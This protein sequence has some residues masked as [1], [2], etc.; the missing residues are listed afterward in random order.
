M[1][2]NALNCYKS[3]TVNNASAFTKVTTFVNSTVEASITFPLLFT[4]PANGALYFTFEKG[5]GANGLQYFYCYNVNTTTWSGCSGTAT[6]GQM[7]NNTTIGGGTTFLSGLPQWDKT[8]GY[9]WFKWEWSQSVTPFW[10][11][12]DTAGGGVPCGPSLLGWTGSGF[13]NLAGTAQT[14]PL[15]QTGSPPVVTVHANIGPSY[16]VLDSISIDSNENLYMPYIDVDGS[17]FLQVYVIVA[18]LHTGTV[19]S[20]IQLTSNNSAFNPPASA[21][22][23][24]INPNTCTTAPYSCGS[25]TQAVTA[26]AVGSCAHVTYADIFNWGAGQADFY[27]CNA[28][29]TNTFQYITTRFSPNQIIFPDAVKLYTQG[30]ISYMF[31]ADNDVQFAFS[32]VVGNGVVGSTTPSV[33]L[34]KLVLVTVGDNPSTVTNA[35]VT[36]A[37]IQ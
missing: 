35:T 26:I 7:F 25:Y 31:I 36:N 3:N 6:N 18:N 13:I 5:G 29:S 9:L 24:G 11:C 14:M 16:H 37:V 12:G 23:L 1:H 17:G 22:W 33:D 21:G 28:F 2:T 15:Q 30:T 20:A 19:G 10:N 27:S 8:T 34:G 32:T 4:N